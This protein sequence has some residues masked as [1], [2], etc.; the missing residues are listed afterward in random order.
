M[1][2]REMKLKMIQDKEEEEAD[3]LEKTRDRMHGKR[4]KKDQLEGKE[5]MK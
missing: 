4:E 1:I 2:S 3:N 5:D